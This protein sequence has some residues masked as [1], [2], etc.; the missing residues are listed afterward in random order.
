MYISSGDTKLAKSPRVKLLVPPKV[1]TVIVYIGCI[2][3][4]THAL[5]LQFFIWFY[6]K[7]SIESDEIFIFVFFIL[8]SCILPATSKLPLMHHLTV[9]V[10]SWLA[11]VS[12]SWQLLLLLSMFSTASLLKRCF[13]VWNKQLAR[14]AG[15]F[16]SL[17]LSD[18]TQQWCDALFVCDMLNLTGSGQKKKHPLHDCENSIPGLYVSKKGNHTCGKPRGP[19]GS[20]GVS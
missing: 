8:C 18:H 17:A 19:S 7:K 12:E 11:D 2:I 15:G 16:V 6:R 14:L 1:F 10:Y 5:H 4:P 20:L 13:I 9:S 3:P